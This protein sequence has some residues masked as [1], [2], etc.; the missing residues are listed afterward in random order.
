MH[1]HIELRWLFW[2]YFANIVLAVCLSCLYL[3]TLS[4][5]PE[6]SSLL[7]L[8]LAATGHYATILLPTF[9]LSCLY[10]IAFKTSYVYLRI[11]TVLLAAGLLTVLFIDVTIYNLYRFHINGMVWNLIVSGVATEI[12]SLPLITWLSFVVGVVV[13]LLIQTILLLCL[14]KYAQKLPSTSPVVLLLAGVIIAS[15]VVY[16]WADFVQYVPVTRHA[17]L[18]PAYRPLTAKRLFSK[19]GFKQVPRSSVWTDPDRSGLRYPLEELQYASPGKRQNILLI[20]ID[21][22]RFDMLNQEA[23]PNIARFAADSWI[24]DTNFSAGNTTRFS[25]FSLLYGIYGTYWKS[26]LAEQKGPVLLTVLERWGYDFGVYAS[27]PLTNPEFDR[28]VFVDILDK[29]NVKQEGKQPVDRDAVITDKMLKFLADHDKE[30]P[31]LGLLFY[32]ATHAKQFPAEFAKHTPYLE[33]V[34]YI[35]LGPGQDPKPILNAYLNALA[36]VDAKVGEVLDAL[37]RQ[38]LLENT[39][40]IITGDHGEEFND[41][42]LN[43]WG[44]NSNFSKYQVG[45]P[46]VMKVP[47]QDP[48]RFT[49]LTTHLDVVPTLMHI[50]FGCKT[51]WSKYSNGMLLTDPGQ[52]PIVHVST[53]DSFAF[54]EKNKICIVENKGGTEVVDSCYRPLQGGTIDPQSSRIALEGMSRFYAR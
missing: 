8:T 20:V 21:S 54:V 25:F 29:I 4:V 32:D 2:F 11:V 43:Y 16:A 45:T 47:G 50:V 9:I 49:H 26:F 15:H 36:Y 53:W 5:V 33:Q 31:F 48:E 17:N 18:L 6:P 19:L 14:N 34:N 51:P 37:K 1:K 27:A 38:G 30:K 28:T 35:T 24:F 41:L 42:G 52:R 23:T 10:I 22:W 3:R 39:V 12:L 44:H 7:Y 40:V 46:L 13:I